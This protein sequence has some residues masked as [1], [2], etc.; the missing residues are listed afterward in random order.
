MKQLDTP[1]RIIT[2]RSQFHHASGMLTHIF[3][4]PP[5]FYRKKV[6]EKA[7]VREE[8]RGKGALM[9][10]L[11]IPDRK[12]APTQRLIRIWR[13]FATEKKWRVTG[14]RNQGVSLRGRREVLG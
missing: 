8:E 12:H 6:L 1:K 13:P 14:D 7:K 9:V 3:N 11:K 4:K 2:H 5:S 10:V